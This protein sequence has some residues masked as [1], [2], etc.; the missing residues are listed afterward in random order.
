MNKG[1]EKSG[2]NGAYMGALIVVN[3]EYNGKN[4]DELNYPQQDGK[5]MY[6]ILKSSGYRN[7]KVAENVE[8]IDDCVE[9][10]VEENQLQEMERFHFHYSG[11]IMHADRP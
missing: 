11:N 3:W 10:F 6:K 7:I 2:K 4:F 9:K 8:D 1:Q 5:D